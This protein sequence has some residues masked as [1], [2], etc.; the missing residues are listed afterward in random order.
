M[1]DMAKQAEEAQRLLQI[2]RVGQ[3]IV[4]AVRGT[5]ESVDDNPEAELDLHVA[6]SGLE[7]YRVTHRQVISRIA[8]GSFRLGVTVPIRVDPHDFQNVLVA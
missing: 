8:I 2:G 3:A 5:G 4:M 1:I 7:P 6:V